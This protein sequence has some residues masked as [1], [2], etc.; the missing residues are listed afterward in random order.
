MPPHVGASRM[1]DLVGL[2]E[3]IAE[4]GITLGKPLHLLDEVESTN[5]SAKQ[6]SREGAPHGS[7]WLAESQ[8]RG[9]GRQGRSWI[10]PR[11]ENL[12]F[13]VLAR[14]TCPVARV[15]ELALVAGLAVRD[16]VA[17]ALGGSGGPQ[18]RLKWPN[19]VLV[20][21]KKIAGILVESTLTGRRVEALVIGVGINVHT[22]SFPDELAGRA[23]SLAL[24]ARAP[25]DRAEVLVDVLSGLHRDLELVAGRGLGLVH[26]RLT[27]AD[28]LAGQAIS[29]EAGSGTAQGID[30][31]GRLLLRRDDGVRLRLTSGEVHL[32]RG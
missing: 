4:R 1:P 13:S 27:E 18:A 30:T 6:A 7:T 25:V 24:E 11:G 29:C 26:A 8:T 28:A 5:D 32:G 15:P 19:D 12:L 14:T 21:Q 23:T 22:R 16:A 31:E 20:G 2:A 10:S 9:R 17:R 3:R